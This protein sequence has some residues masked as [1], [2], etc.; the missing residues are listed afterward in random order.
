MISPTI[1]HD[2]IV[3]RRASSANVLVEPASTSISSGGGYTQSMGFG[4]CPLNAEIKLAG[5][6]DA[7]DQIDIEI[8]DEPTFTVP[9]AHP[10]SP[11]DISN[12][13]TGNI[14]QIGLEARPGYFRFKN[15][16][17]VAVTV[18]IYRL[19]NRR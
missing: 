17:S 4:G 19:P 9:S 18:S 3:M 14:V 1:N 15:P 7:A 13:L 8:C 11:V 12:L 5:N 6:A 10:D 16:S 2:P